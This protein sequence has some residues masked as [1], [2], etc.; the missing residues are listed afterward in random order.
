MPSYIVENR[1][2]EPWK[3]MRKPVNPTKTTCAFSAVWPSVTHIAIFQARCTSTSTK[4]ISH[5][6][7][8]SPGTQNLSAVLAVVNTGNVRQI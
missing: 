3:I 7:E 5:I 8:I 4:T 6:L 1:G 2:M